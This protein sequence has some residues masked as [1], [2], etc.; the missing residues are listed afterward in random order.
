MEKLMETGLYG[1][2]LVKI[3]T[4][5][6]VDRYN[7]SLQAV[8]LVP[9]DLEEFRVDAMGWS[10]EIAEERDNPFYLSHGQA[11]PLAIIL[12]PEQAGKPVYF[13][14]H[15]FDREMMEQLYRNA[16]PQL[17]DLTKESAVWVDIDQEVTRYFDPDDL[18]MVDSISLHFHDTEGLM[19]AA[20]HQRE[21]VHEIMNEEWVWADEDTLDKLIKSADEYGDLRRRS[22][23]LHTMHFNDMRS[24]YTRVLGG[25]FVFRSLSNGKDLLILEQ[26]EEYNTENSEHVIRH[27]IDD[28]SLF[29]D[30]CSL[31][32]VEIDLEWCKDNMQD[33]KDVRTAI[34]IM[35][36][37]KADEDLDIVSLST[38]QIKKQ[39]Q[40][41][42]TIPE[43]YYQLERFLNLLEQGREPD[44]EKLSRRT[45]MLLASPAKRLSDSAQKAAWILLAKL[46]QG[47][48]VD[49]YKY[50]KEG[51]FDQYQTWPENLKRW[52]VEF[53]SE[54][55]TPYSQR[56]TRGD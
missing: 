23:T 41:S 47:D 14:F 32:I 45:Q 29:A 37:C 5:E 21:I 39:I 22:L 55:Y 35:A 20:A 2:G 42:E 56:K 26:P 44:P 12:T 13:R 30:I 50:D 25:V 48:L 40:E 19:E 27:A 15:S 43:E 9:T 1:R 46:R 24:F 6:L 52:A 28:K 4:D 7:R 53:L 8:G 18:L 17:A 33:L 54:R 10:P 3:S 31:G 16:R 38:P 49:T 36:L 51:F 34:A 11:N